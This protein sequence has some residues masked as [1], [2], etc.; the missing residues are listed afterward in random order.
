MI[1]RKSSESV[2]AAM[3]VSREEYNGEFFPLVFK[4][5]TVDNSSEFEGP[6]NLEAYSVKVHF[7]HPYSSREHPQNK[8]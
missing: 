4:T 8:R 3:E 6:S 1:P 2:P 5:I 7:A